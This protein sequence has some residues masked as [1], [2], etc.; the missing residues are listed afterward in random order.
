MNH[1]A[2]VIAPL[3]CTAFE[4]FML[5]QDSPDYPCVICL[6]VELTGNLDTQRLRQALSE[7]VERQ[8]LLRS[9]LQCHYGKLWWHIEETGTTE[10]QVHQAAAPSWPVQRHFDLSQEFGWLAELFPAG[11]SIGPRD[12]SESAPESDAPRWILFLQVHHAI[13]DGLGCLQIVDELLSAYAQP[14]QRLI[15]ASAVELRD[16]N[17]FGLNVKG[18]LQLI[19]KQFVGLA[20]VRQFLSRRPVPMSPRVVAE[21]ASSHITAVNY[22]CTAAQSQ[23]LKQAAKQ[24]QATLN[25]LLAGLVFEACDQYRQ[26]QM[27]Y[28]G[29][30]WLRM[31][32]PMN[33]RDPQSPH[34]P[35]CNMV[36]CIFLDRTGEQIS[37]RDELLKSIHDEMEL[38]KGNRLAFVFIFSLWVKKLLRWRSRSSA[39]VTSAPGRCQTSIVFSNMGKLLESTALA[40]TAEGRLKADGVTLESCDLLAPIA[41]LM[42]VAITTYQYAGRIALSLR[43][44]S[45]IFTAADAQ[46]LLGLLV[47]RLESLTSEPLR[48]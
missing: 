38:I 46:R 31:M 14:G 26:M 47:K 48:A 33:M 24:Q 44:D 23:Q 21:T 28:R 25:D 4:E 35:V 32:V 43:Y 6:R 16:R 15:A 36:S 19:P 2:T 3:R 20:G 7:V 18:L 5:D 9:K 42:R 30:E 13:A 17:R 34:W 41:P 40:T 37:E 8:P 1:A 11:R 29:S 45:T 22:Y 39:L 27:S 12:P 10:L